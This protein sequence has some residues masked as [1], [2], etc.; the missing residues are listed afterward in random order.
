ME[1]ASLLANRSCGFGVVIDVHGHNQHNFTMLGYNINENTL[2]ASDSVIDAHSTSSIL[3]LKVT[4]GNALSS[5]VKG[6]NS[7]GSILQSKNFN[8]NV[9]PSSDYPS[10]LDIPSVGTKYFQ[11]DEIIDIH[12]SKKWWLY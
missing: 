6:A 11:G 5:V 10:P 2:D 4:W 9:V 12:G 7:L 3:A 1:D 8:W